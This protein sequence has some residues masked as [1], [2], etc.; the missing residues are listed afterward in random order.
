MLVWQGWGITAALFPILSVLLMELFVDSPLGANL[1][2]PKSWSLCLGFS[3]SAIPIYILGNKLNNMPGRMLV[4]Q[5]TNEVVEL[6]A[7][8][9]FFWVPLQYWSFVIVGIGGWMYLVEI[10]AI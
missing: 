1:H 7:K 8:H 2:D 9:T 10:G 5:E 4:D 6:K 3:L